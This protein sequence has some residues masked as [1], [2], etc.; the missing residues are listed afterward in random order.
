M[1]ALPSTFP[2][3]GKPHL[4]RTSCAPALGCRRVCEPL[5]QIATAT[6]PLQQT[7]P[8][9]LPR[10]RPR[11]YAPMPP[12]R[13]EPQ[14]PDR[15]PPGPRPNVKLPACD[16]SLDFQRNDVAFS[17]AGLVVVHSHSL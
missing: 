15:L 6:F 3:C 11:D 5:P 16:L 8:P 1:P 10:P 2:L 4:D 14:T 9:W 7:G 13:A 12:G 17:L